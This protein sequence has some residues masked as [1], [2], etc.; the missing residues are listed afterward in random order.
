MSLV[1]EG[2]RLGVVTQEKEPRSSRVFEKST[3]CV[4]VTKANNIFMYSQDPHKTN[5]AT[6]LSK[7]LSKFR[8]FTLFGVKG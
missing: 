8:A 5:E 6:L 1:T 4:R 2:L 7:K 3:G